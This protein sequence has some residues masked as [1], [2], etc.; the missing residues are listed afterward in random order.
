MVRLLEQTCHLKVIAS[1]SD[2][3][4][5]NQHL[6]QMHCNPRE[7]CYITLNFHAPE[8]EPDCYIYF[9]SDPPHLIKTARNDLFHS[10]KTMLLWNN[11]KYLLWQ[12]VRQL[13]E[14]DR[15]RQLKM[16]RKL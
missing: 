13:H 16:L 5:P 2:K 6:Y 10:D 12:H 15:K 3:A 1:T 7:I 4:S 11:G 8:T 9:F 14:D